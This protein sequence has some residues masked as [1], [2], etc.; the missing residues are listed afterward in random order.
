MTTALQPDTLLD[1]AYR[2]M[3]T[4]L[5]AAERE[6]G[7]P[8]GSVRLLAVSKR[9]SAPALAA[10]HALGQV[11]F[12]ENQVQE[13]QVKQATLAGLPLE[14]HYLGA[15]Q[16]NKTQ[17]LA[18]RFHWVQSL[19]RLDLAQRLAAQRPATLP[20]LQVCVQVN[21]DGEPQKRGCAPTAV[22]E[23]MA[24]IA[25]LPQLRLRGL[26]AIPAPREDFAAQRQV[27]EQLRGLYEAL[28]AQG[29][30]L[31]TLSLGM[32]GDWMAAVAAGATLIRV[33]TALFGARPD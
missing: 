5:A 19:D 21:W 11:A 22:A 12:G 20:P 2:A 29:H 28:R 17:A 30:A 31:D 15:I 13:A 32:S 25:C 23:L 8:P 27:F 16:R 7:R 3:Q 1:A 26:M 33:G 10:L 14:W 6:F 24:G 4:Q 18:T 9:Q